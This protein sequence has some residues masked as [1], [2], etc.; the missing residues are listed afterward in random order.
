MRQANKPAPRNEK[1]IFDCMVKPVRHTKITD[2]MAAAMRTA[3]DPCSALGESTAH[4]TRFER[5]ETRFI[6]FGV[7]SV[8]ARLKGNT[9]P[10]VVFTM[11]SHMATVHDVATEKAMTNVH[12]ASKYILRGYVFLLHMRATS[13][14]RAKTCFMCGWEGA[15]VWLVHERKYA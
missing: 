5:L 4:E 12:K 6:P 3:L 14:T 7:P 15:R 8:K 2:V 13:N 11:G 1:S 10:V 9:S